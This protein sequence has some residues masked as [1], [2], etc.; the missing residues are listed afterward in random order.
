MPLVMDSCCVPPCF[1][2]CEA[3]RFLGMLWG[4]LVL[5]ILLMMGNKWS[6]LHTKTLKVAVRQGCSL[7]CGCTLSLSSHQ[8]LDC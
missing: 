8:S 3:L 2:T 7:Q 1:Y 6:E 5:F 4:I